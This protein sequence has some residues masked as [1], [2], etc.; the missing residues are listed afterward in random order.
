MSSNSLPHKAATLLEALH[1]ICMSVVQ[2]S[3][4]MRRVLNSSSH[5]KCHVP[6]R[7]LDLAIRWAC[8]LQQD[9]L[10]LP[11]PDELLAMDECRPIYGPNDEL[12]WAGLR[13]RMGMAWGLV[14]S[15]KPLNTGRADY[16][17]VLA[18]TAARVSALAA[19]GQ[20]GFDNP[21]FGEFSAGQG[22]QLGF[23]TCACPSQS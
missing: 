23:L 1:T 11:W 6:C 2:L 16:F 4:T 18:N 5:N 15:K 12:V 10:S 8:N 14:S 7:R 20:V 9:L 13:V 22:K 19:P 3:A 17:G 21:G